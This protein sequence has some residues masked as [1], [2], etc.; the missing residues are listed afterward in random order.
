MIL[1]N[2][3]KKT[4]ISTN[5]VLAKSIKERTK[6]LLGEKHPR[7]IMIN[8]RFGIH[9]I[10]MK[11][12]IDVLVI[13]KKEHVV[14]IRTEL[15]PN[16]LFIWHPKYSKVVELPEGTIKKTKTKIGDLLKILD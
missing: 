1:K 3:T 2:T 13:D 11:F 14:D 7:S 10:G 6:G 16:S 4:T 15:K 12:P 8:T 9:T 5:T